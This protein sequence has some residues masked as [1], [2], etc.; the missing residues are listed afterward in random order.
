MPGSRGVVQR[1]PHVTVPCMGGHGPSTS[2]TPSPRAPFADDRGKKGRLRW[3]PEL[4]ARF[5]RAVEQL[6]ELA[7][8]RGMHRHQ[9]QSSSSSIAQAALIGSCSA[10]PS[11]TAFCGSACTDP[12]ARAYVCLQAA[13]SPPPP[14]ASCLSWRFRVSDAWDGAHVGTAES[15]P[16]QALLSCCCF[17]FQVRLNRIGTGDT[18]PRHCFSSQAPH[19]QRSPPSSDPSRPIPLAAGLTLHQVK[20]HVQKYRTAVATAAKGKAKGGRKGSHLQP[21]EPAAPS[22]GPASSD[23][24]APGAAGR[25]E[26]LEMMEDEEGLGAPASRMQA[27]GGSPRQQ[28]PP[29]EQLG[30]I[31]SFRDL[32]LPQ[33]LWDG[34]DAPNLSGLLMEWGS[35]VLLA[36]DPTSERPPPPQDA[37]AAPPLARSGSSR[38]GMSNGAAGGPPPAAAAPTASAAGAAAA[39]V[40]EVAQPA[41]P[42][43]VMASASTARPM[44]AQPGQTL[45][46]GDGALR[47]ALRLQLEMQRQLSAALEASAR[48]LVGRR[49]RRRGPP[50]PPPPPDPPPPPPPPPPP[51]TPPHPHP[52]FTHTHSHTINTP[53]LPPTRPNHI[54]CQPCARALGSLLTAIPLTAVPAGPSVLGGLLHGMACPANRAQKQ[55]D[56]ALPDTACCCSGVTF[57]C[58]ASCCRPSVLCRSSSGRTKPTSSSCSGALVVEG[59]AAP[60]LPRPAAHPGASACGSRGRR[61]LLLTCAASAAACHS[62]AP[63]MALSEPPAAPA[64]CLAVLERRAARRTL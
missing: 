27:S 63:C 56:A 62:C 4:H 55:V 42:A 33:G 7:C 13:P 25:N 28:Q 31:A 50:P 52:R 11:M 8:A 29:G 48:V 15:W 58:A 59:A 12:A 1:V 43:A 9:Q 20:S 30:R 3:T 44:P 32:G 16:I 38:S 6:G 17:V 39:A 60:D 54:A 14:S 10:L 24:G 64:P 5:V 23:E 22:A 18:D 21:A 26:W 34:D 2:S 53:T 47:E 45:L 61:R 41:S 40:S 46:L 19:T 57:Q 49:R 36:A 51:Q 35:D 37:P